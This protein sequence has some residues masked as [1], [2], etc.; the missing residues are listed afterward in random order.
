MEVSLK[1]R[2]DYLLY[3]FEGGDGCVIGDKHLDVVFV[4]VYVSTHSDS[5]CFER[6]V[7]LRLSL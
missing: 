4:C 2:D 3:R 7:G 6:A 1:N 5:G